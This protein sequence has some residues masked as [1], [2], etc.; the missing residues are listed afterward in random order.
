MNV[1]KNHTR[2]ICLPGPVFFIFTILFCIILVIL[3]GCSHEE[4]HTARTDSDAVPRKTA[5][6]R[7]YEDEAPDESGVFS[8]AAD[9]A[10]RHHVRILCDDQVPANFTDYSAS[11][12]H[13]REKILAALKTVDKTLSLYPPEFFSSVR[14]GFCD[15]IA[16]CIAGDLRAFHSSSYMESANAF[17][18]IQDETIWLVLNA[19]KEVL[20]GTVIH[21]LT[22]VTDYRLLGMHQLQESEWNLLNPPGFAYYNSYLDSKGSDLR[23]TASKEYTSMKETDPERIYFYDAYSK[24]YA[25]EDRARLME[26]LLEPLAVEA[27]PREPEAS[28]GSTSI[29]LQPDRCFS[30]PH[31]QAKLRFYF[32]TLRQA[33]ENGKWP[34]KTVWETALDAL[35]P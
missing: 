4:P 26:K 31:I 34:E 21:E 16:I 19:G 18:T 24:T 11:R 5:S 13:D 25:M 33:F 10:D 20:P 17:T 22:H 7:T 6:Q 2:Q 23:T 27:L 29:S 3:A 28:S 35:E 30:S 32:Y 12:L 9:I 8:F 15:S 1:T 14:E